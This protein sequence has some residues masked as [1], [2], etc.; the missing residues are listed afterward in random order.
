MEH[1]ARKRKVRFEVVSIAE[2]LRL[3]R[4]IENESPA[5]RL[6]DEK[7]GKQVEKEA[8]RT[9]GAGEADHDV[10]SSIRCR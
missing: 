6:P 4:P 9:P 1:S 3:A 5:D 8:A 2:A 7:A 10:V